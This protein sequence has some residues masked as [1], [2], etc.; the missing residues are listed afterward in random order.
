M[1]GDDSD[2]FSRYKWFSEQSCLTN[3]ALS[4]VRPDIDRA[5]SG[6]ARAAGNLLLFNDL[7]L[8]LMQVFAFDGFVTAC[9]HVLGLP[10][11]GS[12]TH[13]VQRLAS[14]E[15]R[16]QKNYQALLC[17]VGEIAKVRDAWV[18]AQGAPSILKEPDWPAHFED[19]FGLSARDGRLWINLSHVARDGK[20]VWSF[21]VCTL[22]TTAQLIWPRV[23][24]RM[25]RPRKSEA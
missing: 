16:Q 24:A 4:A 2:L 3:K 22:Q 8:L 1:C 7:Q 15:L 5:F 23:Q 13:R 20:R 6:D 9:L 19:R 25:Q 21:V 18:H 11:E 10:K 17:H 14:C 12:L